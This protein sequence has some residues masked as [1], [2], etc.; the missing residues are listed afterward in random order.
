MKSGIGDKKGCNESR[1]EQDGVNETPIYS[2]ENVDVLINA[3]VIKKGHS[4]FI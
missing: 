2:R 4:C 3:K 1:R